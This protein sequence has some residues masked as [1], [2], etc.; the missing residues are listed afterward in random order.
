[1]QKEKNPNESG[2]KKNYKTNNATNDSR[3]ISFYANIFSKKPEKSI[4]MKQFHSDIVSEKYKNNIEVLR[5]LYLESKPA[6]DKQK[7]NLEAVTISGVFESRNKEGLKSLSG[8]MV[9]DIDG[10][11]VEQTNAAKAKLASDPH[12]VMCFISPSG[13]GLKVVCRAEFANDREYKAAFDAISQYLDNK[14]KIELDQSGKD[15]SRACFVSYDPE[16]YYNDKAVLFEYEIQELKPKQDIKNNSQPSLS[17]GRLEKYIQVAIKRELQNISTAPKGMGNSTLNNAAFAIAQLGH[18]NLFNVAD[19]ENSFI[20]AYL[21]RGG[22][23][24]T[25]AESTFKSGW[26]SGASQPRDIPQ[27]AEQPDNKEIIEQQSYSGG[28]FE[29]RQGGVYYIP[30]D[31]ENCLELNRKGETRLS[32]LIKIVADTHNEKNKD[33]GRLL[34]WTDKNGKK[35]SWSMPVRLAQGDG[36]E[37]R[38]E[39]SNNGA[40]IASNKKA[41]NLF[42][43]YLLNWKVKTKCLCTDKLGWYN[44]IFILPDRAIGE[45]GS[46]Q[47]VVF[48]NS[49]YIEPEFATKGT[50]QEWQDNVSKLAAGNS[51]LVFAISAAF[52]GVVLNPLGIEGG[53]F[54]FVGSSSTGK[55]T[56]LYLAGSAWGSHKYK[57]TWR[58]TGNAIEG[59]AAIHN[60]NLLILDEISEANPKEIGQTAYMLA[61][62]QGKGRANKNGYA[63]S[64]QTWRLL[65]LSSGEKTLEE[66]MQGAGQKSTAGQLVR[67]IDI[68]ADAGKG[69]GIFENIATCQTAGSFADLLQEKTAEYHGKA[70]NEFLIKFVEHKKELIPDIKQKLKKLVSDLE[71][72]EGGTQAGRVARRFML[73]GLIGELATQFKI[74]GWSA[75]EAI[76]AAVSCFNSWLENCGGENQESKELKK[77]VGLFFELHGAS[78]FENKGGDERAIINRAGYIDENYYYVLTNVFEQELCRGY[79]LKQAKGTLKNIG[80]LVPSESGRYQKRIRIGNSTP[81]VYAFSKEGVERAEQCN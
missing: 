67:I 12:I 42:N 73:V 31:K 74:T 53:G 24:V 45:T 27:P 58:M 49:N 61:N 28:V 8:C 22:H 60:D 5:A 18:Y 76:Q 81:L 32:S 29:I 46:S 38:Q 15:I 48:Q 56:T 64:V 68:P 37:I 19:V 72:P 25:E 59:Q 66:T 20:N 40:T 71:L 55:T 50:L 78:R 36:Q 62:G 1:M 2:N 79:N 3:N 77:Q 17:N 35:H 70:G 10:L 47:A 44:D 21:A 41:R 63:R 11:T 54:H 69:K 80:W 4:S 34:E 9:L 30:Y 14:Y 52:A 16:A 51:R 6:Y 23:N 57:R 75:G 7:L 39:L 43:D 33:W 65:F 13:H 26:T